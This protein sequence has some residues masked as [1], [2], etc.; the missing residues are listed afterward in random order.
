VAFGQSD[1][2]T[3]TGFAKDPSGAVIPKATV[4]LKREATGVTQRATTNDAGY[5]VFNSISP[6]LYTISV[7]A[8]GFKKFDSVHNKLDGNAILELNASLTVGSAAETVE[9]VASAQTLQTE[10]SAVEKMSRE[11]RSMAWN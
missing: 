10:S 9:V 5:F 7:E 1:N 8:S 4:T 3:I 6:G 11:H 2:G